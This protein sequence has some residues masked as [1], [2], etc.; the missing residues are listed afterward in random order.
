MKLLRQIVTAYTKP[1]YDYYTCEESNGTGQICRQVAQ[2]ALFTMSLYANWKQKLNRTFLLRSP[3][4]YIVTHNT[5]LY[6]V[7]QSIQRNFTYPKD[8]FAQ[9]KLDF[10]QESKTLLPFDIA[11][12]PF[13]LRTMWNV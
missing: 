13:I 10:P 2:V 12:V 8:S 5:Y 9:V 1:L 7:S 4:R 3:G 6:T 11:L